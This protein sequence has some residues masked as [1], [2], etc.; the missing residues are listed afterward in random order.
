MEIHEVG[1]NRYVI[2]DEQIYAPNIATAIERAKKQQAR[3]ITPEELYHLKEEFAYEL[4]HED[5]EITS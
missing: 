3:D 1:N 4:S 5:W 2:D